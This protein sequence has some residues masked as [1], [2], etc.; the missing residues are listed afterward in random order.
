MWMTGNA[1]PNHAMVRVVDRLLRL[2]VTDRNR[3]GV[4]RFAKR[5]SR[6]DSGG[7]AAFL[8]VGPPLRDP[9]AIGHPSGVELPAGRSDGPQPPVC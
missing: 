1:D 6:G 8:R 2:L 7:V 5:R 9:L 3:I 4:R